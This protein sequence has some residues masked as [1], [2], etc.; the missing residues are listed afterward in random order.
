MRVE[1]A[2]VIAATE[3]EESA[4]RSAPPAL[5][6]TSS[7]SAGLTAA[8]CRAPIRPATDVRQIRR[9]AQL[10]NASLPADL[11]HRLEAARDDP[12]EGHR[13]GVAHPAH[14]APAS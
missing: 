14:M 7:P 10:G 6:G 1:V 3:L 13:I 11:A 9:I 5:S 8:G 2:E 4:A 12:A